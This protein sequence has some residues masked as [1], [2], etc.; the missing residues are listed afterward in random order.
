VNAYIYPMMLGAVGILATI[1]GIFLTRQWGNLKPIMCFNVGL[2]VAAG[3][4]VVG[5][6]AVTMYLSETSG[7]LRSR[8]RPRR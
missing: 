3:I 4:S 7:Y 2:F 6:Y 5:A 8:Q 1:V